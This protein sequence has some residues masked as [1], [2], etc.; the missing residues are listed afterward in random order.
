MF[1]VVEKI[2]ELV[3]LI[4]KWDK[5]YYIDNHSLVTDA[6]YDKT[7]REL[8]SLEKKY[9]QLIQS[10][11]PT[12]KV[13]GGI[14]EGFESVKH[15]FP[16]LSIETNT[17]PSLEGFN[18]WKSTLENKIDESI[19]F[20]VEFKFDGL[21]LS[22]E[23]RNNQFY[24]GLTRGDGEYGE[25]VTLNARQVH[26]VPLQL[27]SFNIIEKLIV[28]GEVVMTHQVFEKLN[29][30]RHQPFAN[31][32]NAASGSLRQ[33]DPRVT[34]KRHLTFF[35]YQIVQMEQN[36][37]VLNFK[38]SEIPNILSS[39]GFNPKVVT[40]DIE[41]ILTNDG[42]S[43]EAK[44]LRQLQKFDIDGFVIK[45]DDP[46][47][48]SKLGSRNREPIWAMAVKFTA[49][50]GITKLNSIEV[51]VGRTGKLT[52]VAK[53]TPISIAGSCITNVSLHNAFVIRQLG[54]R[55]NDFVKVHKAGDVIPEITG[56]EKQARKKYLPNFKF[57]K[58]C[59]SCGGKVARLKGDRQ[60]YCT[61]HLGCKEQL[62]Q[63]IIHYTSRNALNIDGFGGK[64]ADQ[65]VDKL[66]I[67]N[68][69]DI[70]KLDRP[71]FL[72]I[73]NVG[74]KTVDNLLLAIKKSKRT[75]F[76]KLLYGLGI[77][78]VGEST[79]KTLANKY[80]QLNN[81]LQA[82]E[83][84]LMSI[85]DIGVTTARSIINFFSN[86]QNK[87]QVIDLFYFILNIVDED[88]I[89]NKLFGKSFVFTGTFEG[90]SREGLKN[91]IE[92]NGGIFQ[93]KISSK[94][95][96][97]VTGLDGGSKILEA[98]RLQVKIIDKEKLFS[99]IN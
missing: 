16:M 95:D 62:K 81:L 93:K 33:L 24:C 22:L 85:N 70:Y 89:E 87:K 20:N 40:L 6:R 79:S 38:Q 73:Q 43:L 82:S 34:A 50:S 15:S 1:A 56:Y 27:K 19:N 13:S 4:N 42:L 41:D 39:L 37:K 75:T 63:S 26:G 8:V 3:A 44:E 52:P 78:N 64:I 68:I 12:Q 71:A 65:L 35:P 30:E 53:I 31:V 5:S 25:N 88:K 45:V 66:I 46:I 36:G 51:Q 92:S 94:T 99:L 96:Y 76:A 11:S 60:Y 32:R 29:R 61:N 67:T 17:N 58:T 55:V 47:Q 28:R 49:E 57:P 59:P 91:L 84:D 98:Q 18:R 21:A 69:I 23:Y 9:P 83:A 2:I 7:Y 72:S 97:L 86:E 10:N 14:Q 54:V 90:I 80:K 77:R 48:Q 74:R